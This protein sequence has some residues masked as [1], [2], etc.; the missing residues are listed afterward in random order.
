MLTVKDLVKL[1]QKKYRREMGFCII[2]GEK[3]VNELGNKAIGI[4]V[5][6]GMSEFGGV[7]LG[8]SAKR[9]SKKDYKQITNL[10]NGDGILAV[11]GIPKSEGI[12]YPYLVLDGVQDPGNAGTILRT[13]CAFG[14]KTVYCINSADVWSQKVIRSAMGAQ[15][16]LNIYE[17][18]CEGFKSFYNSKL[19]MTKLFIADMPSVEGDAMYKTPVEFGQNCMDSMLE[20]KFAMSGLV[21][22]NEGNGVSD[23]IRAMPHKIVSVPMCK[24]STESLNVAVAGG[25]LMHAISQHE[26]KV[27]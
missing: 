14:F 16:K 24:N 9:I 15:F 5:V 19:N 22:G 12:T 17:T 27:R 18:D 6:D 26:I 10:D 8:E 21:L 7:V 3:L 11:M 20:L 1:T 25:I 2:E 4:Y 23:E 13:A